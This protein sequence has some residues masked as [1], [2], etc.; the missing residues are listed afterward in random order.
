MNYYIIPKNNLNIKINLKNTNEINKPYISNSLF[1]YLKDLNNQIIKLEEEDKKNEKNE[2]EISL[3][4]INKIVNPFEFLHTIVPGSNISV[5]K[6]KP[7]SSIFFEL[8]EIFQIF[9]INEIIDFKQKI[10]IA[11]LTHNFS[12]TTYLLNMLR[13]DNDD[14]IL[15]N[16][17][18]YNNLYNL[19]IENEY[20]SKFDLLLFEFLEEDY[21]NSDNYIKNMILVFLIIIKYQTSKGACIIKMDNIFYKPIVDIIFMLTCLFDKIYLIKPSISNVTKGDRYLVC[22]FFNESLV[23]QL[24]FNNEINKNLLEPFKK[25]LLSRSND[26]HILSILDNDFP[27][28]FI[29]KLEESNVVIGQQQLEALDQIINIFNNKNREDKIELLKRNHL[30][31]CIYWC[32]KNQLPHNKFIDKVNIFLSCKKKSIDE[33]TILQEDL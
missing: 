2:T 11:H 17:Y 27:Y 10:N 16:D 25:Y 31:K 5:S 23:S 7:E 15:C 33:D 19:F 14:N 21:T 4:F 9:N 24:N 3:D 18:N 1:F 30:Q 12:S 20:K 29:N 22:K 13:E 8:L 32:E 6:V 26:S 28:Y